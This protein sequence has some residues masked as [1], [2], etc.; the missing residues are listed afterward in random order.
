LTYSTKWPCE[1]THY[2]LAA[3]S[4]ARTAQEAIAQNWCA[5]GRIVPAGS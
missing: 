3:S 1:E 4:T 2:C 5:D